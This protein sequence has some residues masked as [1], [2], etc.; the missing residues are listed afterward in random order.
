LEGIVG[1]IARQAAD[2][3]YLTVIDT[4]G[5]IASLLALVL[6]SYIIYINPQR[7]LNR[8]LGSAVI[9][10]GVWQTLMVIAVTAKE[11]LYFFRVASSLSAIAMIM[12][13]F[14]YDSVEHPISTTADRWKR[15]IWYLVFLGIAS[16]IPL[17]PL[18]VPYYSPKALM[19][20]GPLRRVNEG[21]EALFCVVLLIQAFRSSRRLPMVQR[22]EMQTFT[23]LI[24]IMVLQIL[25]SVGAILIGRLAGHVLIMTT[26][27]Y[28]AIVGL[29][30]TSERIPSRTYIARAAIRGALIF[31]IQAILISPLFLFVGVVPPIVFAL[32]TVGL[33]LPMSLIGRFISDRLLRRLEENLGETSA[34]DEIAAAVKL[35]WEEPGLT[36]Q[37][38]DVL[39][40]YLRAEEVEIVR[41]R[42]P[43]EDWS[44][45][46]H[47]LAMAASAG[48]SV[49]LLTIARWRAPKEAKTLID[50]CQAE[51]LE[52]LV[53]DRG[54]HDTI[55][56][57]VG[58]LPTL[59][60]VGYYQ[61]RF[62]KDA[63]AVYR[64]GI[65]RIAMGRKIAQNERLAAAGYL[66][67]QMSHEARNRLDAITTVLEVLKQ[68]REAEISD[69]HRHLVHD[70]AVKITRD[71]ERNLAMA[72]PGLRTIVRCQA[73][74]IVHDALAWFEGLATSHKVDVRTEFTEG[75]DQVEAD[76]A[77]VCQAV[78]N[79]LR[80]AA[81]ALGDTASATITVRT[82]PTG[83]RFNIEVEDNGP[84]VPGHIRS[85]LFTEFCTTKASG[86]GIGLSMV[87]RSL[88]LIDGTIEYTTPFGGP[89]ACFRIT[90]PIASETS[91]HP[92]ANTTQLSK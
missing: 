29:V 1:L 40:S 46:K 77:L 2:E 54:E 14:V 85:R 74:M 13:C 87:R 62:L 33:L 50:A 68:G 51:G 49:S 16:I 28:Y 83:A 91:A 88:S 12:M 38:Q 25:I 60:A 73:N 72:R 76:V 30:L 44:E 57:F 92:F 80:N 65:E 23:W 4:Y 27:A 52:L 6:G 75:P 21:I 78:Y 47:L 37:V 90:L 22:H 20:Q 35:Q 19:L 17:S 36:A 58:K 84:G 67:A 11:G 26:V 15:L 32:L 71:F 61:I 9:L 63:L 64:T 42:T 34:K 56:L 8:F 41:F 18:W 39:R 79:L 55:V 70:S 66:A 81:E 45:N 5:G 69:D 3:P 10:S 31:L 53:A 7:S 82:F 89:H 48:G 24:G 43:P 59:K 86:T